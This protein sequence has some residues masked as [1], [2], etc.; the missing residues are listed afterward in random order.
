[1]PR[2]YFDV[3]EGDA[4]QEDTEGIDLPNADMAERE[5]TA[6][7]AE[8]SC[9]RVN[10]LGSHDLIVE[11]LDESRQPLVTV[12]LSMRLERNRHPPRKMH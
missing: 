5:A 7:A 11:V 2:F 1:M 9:E 6:A 3:R 12:K 8:I 4:F 10:K